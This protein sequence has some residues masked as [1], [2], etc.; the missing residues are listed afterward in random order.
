M[1][2]KFI[3][4]VFED[5]VCLAG[6]NLAVSRQS[7]AVQERYILEPPFPNPQDGIIGFQGNSSTLLGSS[8]WFQSL[9]DSHTF[10]ECRFGLAL[11]TDDTGTQYLGGVAKDSFVGEMSTV[12]ISEPWTTWGDIVYNGTV[13]DRGARMFTD[14]GTAVIFGYVTA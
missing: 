8:N 3:A 10:D 1:C 12:P 6:S 14:S 11:G 4:K 5:D 13:F 7:I 9:C 2:E